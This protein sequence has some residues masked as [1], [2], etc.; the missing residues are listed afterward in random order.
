MSQLPT[1]SDLDDITCGVDQGSVLGP[2][3]FLVY[4]N[5]IENCAPDACMKLLADDSNVF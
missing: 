2:L 1:L 3:L 4:V 5:D